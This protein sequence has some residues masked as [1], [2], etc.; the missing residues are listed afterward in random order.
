MRDTLWPEGSFV[1]RT[2]LA[3]SLVR[4]DHAHATRFLQRA[5]FGPAPGDV[6]HL[7]EVGIDTWIDEQAAM[8][9]SPGYFDILLDDLD[10]RLWRA[11]WMKMTT[12]SAQFRQR[13][14]YALSQIIVVSM[15]G[16]D[17]RQV[18]HY[19]DVLHANCLGDFRTLLKEVTLTSAMGDYLSYN[20]NRRADSSSGSV[21]DENYAREIMQLFT[22]GLWELEPDGRRK[23][24]DGQP[25]PTY[26]QSDVVGLARV[27]TGWAREVG[28]DRYERF[29]APLVVKEPSDRYHEYGEKRFLSTHISEGT[30]PAKSLE[31]ALDALTD[32]PNVGPFIG[33]QL[34]QRLVTSNPSPEFVERISSVWDDDGEG[35]RGNLRAVVTA[36]LTDAEGLASNPP[37][38]FGKLREPVLRWTVVGR[39]LGA[40]SSL[41]HWPFGST[42]DGGSALGQ[43][44]FDAPSVFNFYRPGYTPPGTRIADAGLVAPELQLTD[45]SSAIGWVNWLS[46]TL[47]RP[48]D[49][50]EY[51][52][53]DLVALVDRPEA[54][55]DEA[56]RR[57]CPGRLSPTTRSTIVRVIPTITSNDPAQQSF[58]KVMTTFALV[59]AS[60]D[61]LYER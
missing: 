4:S 40:S 53:S 38:T 27:F 7:R 46:R 33:K 61:F 49:G 60:N 30:G 18:A 22:I 43:Q 21:P 59:A 52:V 36:I 3:N 25:I 44:P 54:L 20:D 42:A 23:M 5:T 11:V 19:V 31:I 34:I 32:H 8:N 58:M 16:V 48:P 37:E 57:L 41:R 24:R 13:I 10:D 14:A 9:V 55:V 47:V 39:A 45:A 29:R 26:E 56:E 50:L 2:T 12:G 17:S 6:E 28:H 35:V 15:S 51:E 1:S